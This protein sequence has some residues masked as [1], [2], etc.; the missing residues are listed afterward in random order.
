MKKLIILLLLGLFLI[1]PVGAQIPLP[2][3]HTQYF[4]AK[5]IFYRGKNIDANR[6]I[7]INGQYIDLIKQM[8]TTC[9]TTRG[10]DNDEYLKKYID[11]LEKQIIEK[12]ALIEELIKK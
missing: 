10:V 9:N 11:V 3:F 12:D 5:G 7:I 8:I 1:V 4:D 2:D 6:D